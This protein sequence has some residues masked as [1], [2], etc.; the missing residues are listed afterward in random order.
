MEMPRGFYQAA[1]SAEEFLQRTVKQLSGAASNPNDGTVKPREPL[2]RRNGAIRLRT[3]REPTET[4]YLRGFSGGDYSD[5]EWQAADDESIFE[6][7]ERIP[8]IGAGGAIDSRQ[9]CTTQC[10]LS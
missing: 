4:I 10:I 8:F 7:M 6:R 9:A 1:Y 5:G 2:S 3:D